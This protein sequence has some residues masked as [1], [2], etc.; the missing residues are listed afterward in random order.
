MNGDDCMRIKRKR[1][2][3]SLIFVVIMFMFV[4]IV[5]SAMLS[6]VSSNYAGRVTESKRVKNLYGAESGLDIA[7]NVIA[8]T[9]DNANEYSYNK[10]EIFKDEVKNMNY[11]EFLNVKDENSD[12]KIKNKARLYALYADIDYLQLNEDS[13]KSKIEEDNKKIDQLINYVFRIYFKDYI[14]ANLYS[15][16]CP[17]GENSGKG[18][19]AL[20]GRKTSNDENNLQEV[21]YNNARISFKL[22][23]LDENSQL[24]W[25][26]KDSKV[27]SGD[28]L[29]TK[30]YF[31]DEDKIR[32]ETY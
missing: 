10:T 12:E 1:K 17:E 29:V 4:I 2:G 22:E 16:I 28:N 14:N 6:M 8:K 23:S 20:D 25:S 24:K 13:N 26:E 32:K 3:S 7:Y 19:Y 15:N 21:I 5:S 18:K 9:I 11:T 31:D 30:Y 27:I